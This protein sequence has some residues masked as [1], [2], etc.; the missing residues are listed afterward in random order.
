M[1]AAS[2]CCL[3]SKMDGA[4]KAFNMIVE[5]GCSLD[6]FSY[7]ILMNGYCKNK[8]IDEAMHLFHKMSNKGVTIDV[9]TYNTL[10][11]GFCRVERP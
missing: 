5:R 6:V 8:R 1:F 4:V 11:G 2:D 9:V 7:N 3:Q 10:I